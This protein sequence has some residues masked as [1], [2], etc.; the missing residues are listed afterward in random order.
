MD[1]RIEAFESVQLKLI[2]LPKDD[3]QQSEITKL[4]C[5]D[6]DRTVINQTLHGQ[7]SMWKWHTLC[8]E[9]ENKETDEKK[10]DSMRKD[11][12]KSVKEKLDDNGITFRNQEELKETILNAQ[13]KG[14]KV[15]I[16][17]FSSFPFVVEL[18]MQELLGRESA[19]KIT[20]AICNDANVMKEHR[21]DILVKFLK[22]ELKIKDPKNIILVDDDAENFINVFQHKESII[23]IASHANPENKEN[24]YLTDMSKFIT[25]QAVGQD[26]IIQKVEDLVK[27]NQE[28]KEGKSL[29]RS[30]SLDLSLGQTA[31]LVRR[32]SRTQSES[33][34]CSHTE[35]NSQN[36]HK[37]R[38][39]VQSESGADSLNIIED[40]ESSY[41]NIDAATV[42]PLSAEK[43]VLTKA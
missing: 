29:Q 31:I 23:C 43:G 33:V 26:E 17:S 38:L 11:L 41:T 27:T 40:P 25:G 37:R 24:E 15:A 16:T 4:I 42:A 9:M 39:R 12:Q 18:L 30:F 22:D 1:Y 28:K 7:N 32:R 10:L 34:S 8:R 6:F 14:I 2:N 20:I 36:L 21:K 5:L 13:R 19:E 35:K 3:T